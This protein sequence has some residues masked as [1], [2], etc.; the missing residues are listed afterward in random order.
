M[1]APTAYT[2]PENKL[3]TFA[4]LSKTISPSHVVY[5]D[6]ES[7]LQS[8]GSTSEHGV[9]QIHMPLA[10]AYIIKPAIEH[11]HALPTKYEHFYGKECIVDFLHSLDMLSKLVSK[12]YKNYR[13]TPMTELTNVEVTSYNNAIICYLCGGTFNDDDKVKDHCHFSGKFLGAA[14][15]H[16]NLARRIKY[17]FL[18]IVFHNL[19]GYD[20]HHIFKHAISKFKH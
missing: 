1:V 10:A 7:L 15:N 17:P 20:M 12:W 8:P 14:C 3:L 11:A 16:C 9:Q 2:M 5:A 18:P 13:N 6:F 4:D 19:K